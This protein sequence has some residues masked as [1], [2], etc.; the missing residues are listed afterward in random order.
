MTNCT[1]CAHNDRHTRMCKVEGVHTDLG[2]VLEC[3]SWEP[4]DDAKIKDLR[5][6]NAELRGLVHALLRCNV[7][8]HD[9]CAKCDYRSP[10]HGGCMADVKADELGIEVS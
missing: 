8:D 6:Q 5:R 2:H 7:E 9:I 10:L 4:T 1:T 3:V